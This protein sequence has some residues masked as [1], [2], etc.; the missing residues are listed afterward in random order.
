MNL[1]LYAFS[2]IRFHFE[3]NGRS[4]S[5]AS[6]HFGKNLQSPTSPTSLGV[7][8]LLEKVTT[9]SSV[10]TVGRPGKPATKEVLQASGAARCP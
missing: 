6:S 5:V 7:Q 3:K 10:S 1:S 2:S 9:S 8:G 4:E